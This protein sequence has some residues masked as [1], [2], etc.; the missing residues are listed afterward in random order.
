[1][2]NSS[3]VQV[4]ERKIKVLGLLAE[5]GFSIV[6]RVRQEVSKKNHSPPLE[7]IRRQHSFH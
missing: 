6:Y 1:M 5:G 7:I 3:S 2:G 4:N